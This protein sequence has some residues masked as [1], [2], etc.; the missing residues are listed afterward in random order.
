MP[1]QTAVAA[2]GRE[3]EIFLDMMAAYATDNH[4]YLLALLSTV[5]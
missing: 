3:L 5:D 1:I 2:A 4:S